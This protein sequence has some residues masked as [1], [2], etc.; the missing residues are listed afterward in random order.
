MKFHRKITLGMT[1]IFS[2]LFVSLQVQSYELPPNN[3]HLA[4]SN[5]PLAHANAA[6]QDSVAVAGPTGPTKT[7]TAYQEMSY[8]ASGPFQFGQMTSGPYANGRRVLWGSGYDRI[9]KLDHDTHDVLAL[10]GLSG[11]IFRDV[12]QGE[13]IIKTLDAMSGSTGDIIYTLQK[14]A[15]LMTDLSGVYTLLDSNNEFY[16][17]GNQRGVRTITVYGD[18][19][20]G[21]PDSPI[22]VK[23]QF[24]LPD[25][26]S[27]PMVGMNMTYDGHIIV[28]TEHGY[29]LAI[30]PDFSSYQSLLL[31]YAIVEDAVNFSASNAASYGWVRNPFAIDENNAIYIASNNHMHKVAWNGAA[32]SNV[33]AEPYNNGRGN[34]TGAGPTLMGFGEEDKFVV[35][36]DGDDLMNMVLYWRDDI[37][38]GWTQLPGTLSAR[39]AGQ[40][41]CDIGGTVGQIQSEQSVVVAG[42]GAMVVNNEPRNVPQFLIDAN[43]RVPAS[44]VGWLGNKPMIQPYG[45]QKFK[46]DSVTQQ[47]TE[48]WTNTNVSSINA[49]PI[50][51]V[52]SDA[53]YTVGA[54]NGEFTIEALNWSDGSEL[55]HWVLGGARF[56]SLYAGM[57][58]DETGRLHYTALWGKIRLEVQ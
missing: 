58:L 8:R 12:G 49:V 23:R 28:A 14:Y 37:P 43:P 9:V 13:D 42:Y 36:T 55:F 25:A 54:R 56:N 1:F 31:N 51:S 24:A 50:V 3:P 20:A 48:D 44:V 38:S 52:G 57:L 47:L 17:G 41:P 22:V 16:V 35:I 21:N 53:V 33:W 40:L 30:K 32:L 19:E 45:V 15:T 26:I 39:I 18:A 46:W 11:K 34:G 5:Y 4:N 2:A 7:L 6:Q 10:Y 29:L 27:G